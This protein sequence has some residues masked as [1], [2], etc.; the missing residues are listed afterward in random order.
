MA[1]EA[2]CPVA[3]DQEKDLLVL[4]YEDE[5]LVHLR[6]NPPDEGLYG[7]SDKIRDIL[8]LR[9]PFN[10][11]ASR[12][13]LRRQQPK[14][15]FTKN[16]LL[17]DVEGNTLLPRRWKF[18]AQ[19]FLGRT[20]HLANNKLVINFNRWTADPKYRQQL[21]EALDVPFRDDHRDS[22]PAYGFGS[23]F[24]RRRFDQRGSSMKLTHR[25]ELFRDDPQYL[26]FFEDEELWEYSRAIFGDLIDHD[27][28]AST[29]N[30]REKQSRALELA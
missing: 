10:T 26:S 27:S 21:C 22:V 30:S 12:L 5:R 18:L 8:L 28:I 6:G 4:A 2:I 15:A 17:P 19:E 29:L 7:R 20:N 24:D 14:N 25:W 23:S 1:E 3:L 11:F 9:D 13:H 16:F